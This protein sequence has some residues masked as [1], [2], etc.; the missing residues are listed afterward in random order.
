[1][2]TTVSSNV[3]TKPGPAG[4]IE[5]SATPLVISAAWATDSCD[6][7]RLA[8]GEE[9]RRRCRPGQRAER[10]GADH[11]ARPAGDRRP[12]RS[13]RRSSSRRGRRAMIS[14]DPRGAR[15][16]MRRD[17]EAEHDD[18]QRDERQPEQ[19]RAA[20]GAA[21][22]QDQHRDRGDGHDHDGVDDALDD[23]RAQD[24]RP[25]DAFPL[26]ERVAAVQLPESRRQDVVGQIADVG[27]AED[28]AVSE[29]GDRREQ[30]PPAS[31]ARADVEVVVTSMTRIQAGDAVRRTANAALRSTEWMRIQIATTLMAIPIVPRS[32]AFRL[33]RIRAQSADGGG[34]TAW[35]SG[36]PAAGAGGTGRPPAAWTARTRRSAGSRPTRPRRSS[37]S[38]PRSRRCGRPS[39]PPRPGRSAPGRTRSRRC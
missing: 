26:T 3:P 22:A 12:S 4:T 38:G 25:A 10:D 21:D 34:R 27:V 14:V 23:D 28:T 8:G 24:R 15:Q 6:A 9:G 16:A 37:G 1:M 11:H 7:D 36:G 13:R 2:A 35:V 19:D 5:T 33:I 18:H 29:R 32:N 20:H 39:R 17:P 30:G 31:A